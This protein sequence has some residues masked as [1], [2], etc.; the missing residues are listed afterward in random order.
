ME[1]YKDKIRQRDDKL[2]LDGREY[3][4]ADFDALPANIHPRHICTETRGNIT[5]FFRMDSPL[6]NHHPCQIQADHQTFNCVEQG[7]FYNKAVICGDDHAK[8]RIMDTVDPGLQKSIG[9]KIR[10]STVW[11][12]SRIAV[13]ERLCT[14][15]FTQNGSLRE[16]LLSTQATHLA[17][18]SINDGFWGIKMSRNN[19][20]SDNIQH[21]KANNLGKI[22]MRIRDSLA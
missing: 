2:I 17:E 12:N 9:E 20:R 6:S 3:G 19:P 15:K 10:E 18:D 11:M 13:M 7:Y 5:F 8:G 22:L 14:A 21:H 1:E 4:V 16:F